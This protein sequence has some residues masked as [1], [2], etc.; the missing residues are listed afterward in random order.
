M[1]TSGAWRREMAKLYSA[2]I[3][4]EGGRSSIPETAVIESIS[5][6]VLDH[7]PSRVTTAID[8][9]TAHQSKR[10]AQKPRSLQPVAPGQF[11]RLGDADSHAGGD[12]GFAEPRMQRERRN[13]ERQFIM[14]DR[15]AKRL[16]ELAG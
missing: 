14:L 1:H 3:V 15:D 16:A 9:D 8:V 13:V 6:G 11:D 10:F 4:R 7:P 12:V 5:R 2:V